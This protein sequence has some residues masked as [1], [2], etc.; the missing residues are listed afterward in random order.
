MDKL[1][2]SSAGF[3][4]GTASP[5]KAIKLY[6][7]TSFQLPAHFST[8][9]ASNGG[10]TSGSSIKIHQCYELLS[11]KVQ[12]LYITDGK[13][14]DV[15]YWSEGANQW[16]ESGLHI[17]DLGY[18]KVDNLKNIAENNACFLSRHKTN[19]KLYTLDQ[20]GQYVRF[21]LSKE[22]QPIDKPCQWNLFLGDDKVAVR[23]V[24]EKVPEE[25]KNKR[26]ATYKSRV[27]NQTKQRKAWQESGL[28]K[29]LCGYNLFVTNAPENRL[30]VQ[31]VRAFYSLRWQIELL[32]K[33]WKSLLEIDK[34][35]KM[36]IFRFE[37]YLY[38]KLIMILVC[39]EIM[40]F[41]RKDFMQATHINME[42]SEWKTAKLIKKTP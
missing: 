39:T 35:P 42:I 24:V 2:F 29:Q 23:L 28:K 20:Y 19:N 18:W 9:Y 6:D 40:S 17:A 41:I 22:I 11:G 21:D 4:A 36:S 27:A 37:C 7:S 1:V 33:I 5:F 3:L 26:I 38:A 8:F 14:A 15:Q 34:I 13:A 30:A 31:Q 32:F 10:S 12:D 16:V 25:V